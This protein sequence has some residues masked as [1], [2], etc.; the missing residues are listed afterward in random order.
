MGIGYAQDPLN[1][2]ILG[3]HMC[4]GMDARV[5]YNI[6]CFNIFVCEG[7]QMTR[8]SFNVQILVASEMGTCGSMHFSYLSW[9][10]CASVVFGHGMSEA[11]GM[12][13]RRDCDIF[14]Q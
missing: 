1:T 13:S 4:L 11:A 3:T 7:V 14:N 6:V 5:L 12:E 10:L 9:L 8:S 2:W